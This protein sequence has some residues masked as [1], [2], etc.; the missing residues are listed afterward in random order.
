MATWGVAALYGVLAISFLVSMRPARLGRDV[1]RAAGRAGLGVPMQLRPLLLRRMRA[2]RIGE[3]A[4]AALGLAVSFGVLERTPNSAG[5]SS[6]VVQTLLIALSGVGAALGG[7]VA[8]QATSGPGPRIARE[9]VPRV[10][11]YISPIERLVVLGAAALTTV[12]GLL[13]LALRPIERSTAPSIAPSTAL[14]LVALGVWL[15]FELVARRIVSR[16]QPAASA[17]HLAWN[18]AL[19]SAAIRRLAAVSAMVSAFGLALV[20]FVEA[21]ALLPRSSAQ[22]LE[23]CVLCGVAAACIAARMWMSLRLPSR[24]FRDRLWPDAVPFQPEGAAS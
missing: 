8:A 2:T 7:L 21:D 5:S 18:D 19:R 4:G 16:P 22:L 11:D 14:G 23:L 24:Y 17:A 13:P 9:H 12:V 3:M 20:V 10:A 15:V 6:L 1:D